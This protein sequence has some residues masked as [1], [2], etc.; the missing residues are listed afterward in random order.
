MSKRKVKRLKDKVA[1]KRSSSTLYELQQY[2][3]S[4]NFSGQISH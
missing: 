4:H 1:L 3:D 2:I